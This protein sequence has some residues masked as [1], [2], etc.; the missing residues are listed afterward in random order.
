MNPKKPKILRYS[1]LLVVALVILY[2]LASGKIFSLDRTESD[3]AQE[4]VTG[5]VLLGVTDSGNVLAKNGKNLLLKRQD[6]SLIFEKEMP[7]AEF[8]VDTMGGNILAS[9]ISS[10]FVTLFHESGT[11][12]WETTFKRELVWARLLEAGN[13]SICVR[14]GG[15]EYLSVYNAEGAME[16][17]ELKTTY[18]NAIHMI[19][20][21]HTNTVLAQVLDVKEIAENKILVYQENHLISTLISKELIVNMG[22]LN[23][24]NLILITETTVLCYNTSGELLW[25]SPCGGKILDSHIAGNETVILFDDESKG[26]FL[27]LSPVKKIRTL[28]RNGNILME[29]ETGKEVEDISLKESDKTVLFHTQNQIV[30]IGEDGK[31]SVLKLSGS[32]DIHLS[33]NLDYAAALEKDT[34]TVYSLNKKNGGN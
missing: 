25:N 26:G 6:G 17:D 5:D 12:L 4:T 34:V 15:E 27:N 8:T 24:G 30:M 32:L 18:P 23:N 33:H 7:T 31:E 22:I 1:I 9:D 11:S 28:D 3:P 13:T 16:G 2:L 10:G 29:T 14:E 20:D 21:E 19:Y